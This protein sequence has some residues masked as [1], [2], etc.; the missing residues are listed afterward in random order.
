MPEAHISQTITPQQ[1]LAN[2]NKEAVKS[3]YVK[4]TTVSPPLSIYQKK[5]SNPYTVEYFNIRDFKELDDLND[6][7][8]L[9]EKIDSIE[10]FVGQEI[11]RNGMEDSLESYDE[12]IEKLTEQLNLGK[13]TRVTNKIIRLANLINLLNRKIDIES[14]IKEMIERKKYASLPK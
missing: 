10:N 11:E 8:G 3:D 1:E 4:E 14:Q 7:S 9:R 6:I 2:S 5:N 13:N 12:I